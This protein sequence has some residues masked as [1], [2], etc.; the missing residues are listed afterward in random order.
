MSEPVPQLVQPSHW[1]GRRLLAVFVATVVG[2]VL[3]LGLVLGEV[4]RQAGRQAEAD[5]DDLAVAL[6]DR[7]G[8]VLRRLQADLEYLAVA[9][10]VEALAPGGDKQWE[11][12]VERQLALEAARFPEI[13]G[14]RLLDGTGRLR[15]SSHP[16]RIPLDASDR[17]YFTALRDDPSLRLFFSQVLTSRYNGRPML[18]VAVPL[19]DARGVFRGVLM[20]PLA[21]DYLQRLLDAARLGENS[22]LALL[23]SDNE[24]LI[25]SRQQRLKEGEHVLTGNPLQG[26][27]EAGER[28]GNISFRGLRDGVQRQYAWRQVSDY[29]FYVVAGIAAEDYLANWRAL[30]LL[31]G[32]FALFLALVLGLLLRRLLRVEREDAVIGARLADSEERYRL[33][34][35][36][37]HD[38]I[39][40]LDIA[41][42]SLTYV[43]PSVLNLR[44]YTPDEAVGQTLE[45]WLTPNSASRLGGE[46][47][48]HLKRIAAGDHAAQIVTCELEQLRRDGGS[49]PTEVVA[50]YLFD[51]EGVPRQ[52]LGITRDVSERKQ[53][54]E[55]LRESNRQLQLRLDEIGRLQSA[56]Q[57]QALRDGLT[58]LYNRRYLDG[59]LEREVSRV[60]REGT[61]LSLVMLDIDHFKQ[62]NDTYG[63]QAGDEVLRVLAATL[64][65]DIRAEDTACRYG[66]EE[67][68]IL[69]PNMP[70]EAAIQ[71]AEN[72]R[73]A[74]E[75]LTVEHGE[76]SIAFTISLGVAAYPEHGKTSDDLIRCADQALYQA[77]AAG[78]NRVL[79]YAA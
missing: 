6:E 18:A 42:R 34:A 55:T 38:V 70:L 43:S 30:V 50:S 22:V 47:K 51:A 17:D 2:A 26:R 46:I 13:L 23:R 21:L 74:V 10:P 78:R 7:L 56:L 61:H 64:L 52:M 19:R 20:A 14:Y 60:R 3:L 36:N 1:R 59:M 73:L 62:V 31:T 53:A 4:Y 37:S 44:G 69:L 24:S 75:G 39:W 16:G 76:F 15:Y 12:V 67:F 32:L 77:K 63:H 28:A 45:Q 41:S 33:L 66:G 48:R 29:P 35:E 57:E 40:T 27:L 68:L 79:A 5:A 54:E 72:W 58:H 71:R 8:S 11:L 25:L 49:V 9:L 65:A